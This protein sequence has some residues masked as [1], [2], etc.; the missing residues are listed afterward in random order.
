MYT[1]YN[2]FNLITFDDNSLFLFASVNSIELTS[3]KAINNFNFILD[4]VYTETP[5]ILKETILY[6]SIVPIKVYANS[7]LNKKEIIQ[8]NKNKA[9]IY[10]FINLLTKE[11]Y[12]GSSTNLSKRLGQY[13]NY[14]FISSP[15]RGKSVIYSSILKYGYSNHSLT[16]LEYCNVPDTISR[17]QFYIDIIK[18]VMNILPNAGSSL[19][20]ILSKETRDKISIS[21]INAKVNRKGKVV[22][23]KAKAK[24][25]AFQ[26]TRLKHPI[27]GIRVMITNL[28]TGNISIYSSTRNAAK[29]LNIGNATICRRIK[30]DNPKPYKDKFLIRPVNDDSSV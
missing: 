7:D 10:Q 8:D 23:E 18:P 17:E 21:L 20:R 4:N 5:R 19:G 12:I 3:I 14:S 2:T 11:C 9:G 30:L 13:Y 15:A 22:S 6:S 1:I 16:I 24:M 29:A 25:S 27:P 26:S 28:E